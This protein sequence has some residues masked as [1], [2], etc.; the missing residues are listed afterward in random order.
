[1]EI[2]ELQKL[3][4]DGLVQRKHWCLRSNAHG[5]MT[6]WQMDKELAYL[7]P[8]I[9]KQTQ[10]KLD[11]ETIKLQKTVKEIKQ[12]IFQDGDMKRA[13]AR[14]L[15]KILS[16]ILSEKEMKGIMRQGYKILRGKA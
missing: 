4:L 9:R 6:Q 8:E 16:P 10:I 1:M 2:E 7:E 14:E 13:V 15:I 3:D 11:A 5:N 12:T